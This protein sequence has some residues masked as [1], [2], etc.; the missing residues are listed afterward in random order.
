MQDIRLVTDKMTGQS[1]GYA[2]ITMAS[3]EDF[4]AALMGANG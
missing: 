1:R 3:Q 4:M 2:F